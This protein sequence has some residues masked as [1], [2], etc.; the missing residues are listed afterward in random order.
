VT[1]DG[2]EQKLTLDAD[3]GSEPLALVV[4]VEMGAG[5]RAKLASYRNLGA[6][7]DAVVGAV[8]HRIAVVAFDSAPTLAQGFTPDADVAGE[9]LNGLEAGDKALRFWMH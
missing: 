7:I 8:P 1:D 2:V 9:A 6:V 3:T 4:A 5:G